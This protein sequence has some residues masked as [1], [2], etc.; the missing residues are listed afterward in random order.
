MVF[1]LHAPAQ[2]LLQR[3]MFD[4]SLSLYIYLL[5]SSSSRSKAYLV[6]FSMSSQRNR[7]CDLCN[8]RKIRCDRGRP[9]VRCAEAGF[10]CSA[11]RQQKRPG[12]QSLR[13]SKVRFLKQQQQH[14]L[15][16]QWQEQQYLPD[17]QQQQQQISPIDSSEGSVLLPE[18]PSP[19]QPSDT[20]EF[21]LQEQEQAAACFTTNYILPIP[22]WDRGC[23]PFPRLRAALLLYQ[24]KLY[25]IWPLVNV[26]DLLVRLQT[27]TADSRS[28]VL[29]TALCGATLSYLDGDCATY[30]SLEEHV[31]AHTFVAESRRVRASFDYMDAV[32]IDTI[33]TS[34]FLHMHY[35]RQPSRPA[36]AAFYIR[37]AITFAHLLGLHNEAAYAC[38]TWTSREQAVLRRLYFL[39]FM[40]ERYLCVEQGLPTVLDSIDVPIVPD[41]D[42]QYPELVK[43]FFQ[44]VTLFSTP[45]NSF[46]GMWRTDDSSNRSSRVISKEQLLLIERAIQASPHLPE[47]TTSLAAP[48]AAGNHIQ[49]VD[50]V[51]SRHWLRCLAWK[52]SITCGYISSNSTTPGI[53]SVSYPLEIAVD[54]LRDTQ[55]FP[56]QAFEAHGPGMEAKMCKIASALADSILCSP[57]GDGSAERYCKDIGA[58]AVLRSLVDRIFKTQAMSFQLRDSL[59]EKVTELLEYASISPSLSLDQELPDDDAQYDFDT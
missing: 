48:V 28:Y 1:T 44:L 53:L 52:L 22:P 35:G 15:E 39:L 20:F 33:L 43:G 21:S 10:T 36:M 7:A 37:E 18:S 38:S 11:I 47:S 50:I 54:T 45:G 19:S 3:F 5:L 26:D 23:I 30:Q 14:L 59:T 29:A 49:L 12:P 17:L 32:G 25:G 41:G 56:K 24:E 27:E 6:T 42:E 55:A 58:R 8:I 46:F 57:A 16:Q 40:T 2:P 34:Y 13:Q 31:S 9:C 4:S 51:V